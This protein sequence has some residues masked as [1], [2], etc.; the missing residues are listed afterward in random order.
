[1]SN[2]SYNNQLADTLSN[3]GAEV[4]WMAKSKT[5]PLGWDEVSL[6]KLSTTELNSPEFANAVLACYLKKIR[7]GQAWSSLSQVDA[8]IA[9]NAKQTDFRK[10]ISFMT[11]ELEAEYANNNCTIAEYRSWIPQAY[12][13]LSA[14][15]IKHYIYEGWNYNYDVTVP[16]SDGFWLHA[17]RTTTQML[18]TDDM[19]KYWTT[20]GK[21]RL[22]LITAEAKK[23]G[24]IV[25][26]SLLTSSEP[27]PANDG[28]GFGFDFYK[29]RPFGS[30]FPLIQDSFNRLATQDMKD[31]LILA[32]EVV[33]VSKYSKQA[34]P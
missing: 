17:Y 4:A 3:F 26:V 13:K 33:F 29:S 24:K 23:I 10:K 16:N 20:A 9:Y 30:A 21:D 1:M 22:I 5:N 32:G 11:P 14:A 28:K 15:G 6:Y 2:G 19:W 8:V 25:E 31:Y 18:N 27:A 12:A 34:R 7:I